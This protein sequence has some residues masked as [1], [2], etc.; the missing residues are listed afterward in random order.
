MPVNE[1][2][3]FLTSLDVCSTV[4]NLTQRESSNY[5]YGGAARIEWIFIRTILY[6]IVGAVHSCTANPSI[7]VGIVHCEQRMHQRVAPPSHHTIVQT[8]DRVN[9]IYMLTLK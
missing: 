8:A 7:R 1:A 9:V 4:G 6:R 2:Y 3:V 5:V